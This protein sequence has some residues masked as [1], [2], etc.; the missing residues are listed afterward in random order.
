M[1]QSHDKPISAQSSSQRTPTFINT[2]RLVI[3][4]LAIGGVL[5]AAGGGYVVLNADRTNLPFASHGNNNTQTQTTT[6]NRGI[7][8]G[9]NNAGNVGSNSGNQSS[10]TNSGTIGSSNIA[11]NSGVRDI[12]AGDYSTIDIRISPQDPKFQND[13]L[14]G[15]FPQ[16][17]FEAKPPQLSDFQGAKVF[18]KE[19]LISGNATFSD[20]EAV[21]RGKAYKP[22]FRLEGSNSE[23]RRS[24]FKLNGRQQAVL[25]QFGLPDLA[26]GDTN[27]TYQVNI[28]ADGTPIWSGQVIY[29][30][31]QQLLS[32]PLNIPEATTLVVEYAV[33][34]G[35]PSQ[36]GSLYFT[37]AELLYR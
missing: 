2:A 19:L 17:G 26:A 16:R 24:A 1:S 30:T 22:I 5:G 12:I 25:L 23:V 20:K 33:S 14:P 32:V 4:C 37:R 13:K 27:L 11:Q 21:I 3:W 6:L 35:R 18:T 29:G 8:I 10:G 9:G 15:Y 7:Q 31:N 28:S 36:L 34:Q